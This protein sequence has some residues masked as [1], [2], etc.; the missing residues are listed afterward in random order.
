MRNGGKQ[1]QPEQQFGGDAP[2]RPDIRG[3]TQSQSENDLRRAIVSRLEIRNPGVVGKRD[4]AEVDE[5]D[6]LERG[7]CE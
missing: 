5:A 1:R 3:R 2:D 6:G 7:G 4:G